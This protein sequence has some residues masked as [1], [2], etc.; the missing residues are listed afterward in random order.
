MTGP[1]RP[2][3]SRRACPRRLF[4]GLLVSVLGFASGRPATASLAEQAQAL[5]ERAAAHIRA[6]GSAQ[7]F[8]DISRPDG[9]FTEGE[10]YVFCQSADGHVLA[11]GG[12]PRLV[13]RN[14]AALRDAEGRLPI[15]EINRVGLTDGQGWVEYLWPNPQ[16]HR[17]Q[18]K[19]T[20]VVRIDDQTVCGS[21]FYKADQP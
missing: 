17:V 18:R 3:G 19:I 15:V 8:A 16:T 14:L 12:N 20:Y 9:A 6:I 5:V 10:L 7:G 11:N 1:V 2:R 13:G 21:G 4:A